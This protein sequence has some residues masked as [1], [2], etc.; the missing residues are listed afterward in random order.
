MSSSSAAALPTERLSWHFP[1]LLVRQRRQLFERAAYYGMF[2]A[3]TLYLTDRIGFDDVWTGYVGARSR[4]CCICCRRS[5]AFWPTASIG[6][7]AALM[8]AFAL[9]A[10]GYSLLGVAGLP[11]PHGCRRRDRHDDAGRVRPALRRA[12]SQAAGC[13]CPRLGHVRRLDHQAG[14][15]RH[16][17]PVLERSDAGPR[18]LH[19][20]RDG[21]H[22]LVHGQ[23]DRQHAARRLQDPQHRPAPHPRP[24]IHPASTPPR[25]R[26]W[27]SSSFASRIATSPSVRPARLCTRRRRA[28]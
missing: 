25:W 3:L 23:V 2:I 17:R 4:R 18:V 15:H 1:R 10:A 8:L 7:R 26:C 6:F 22:W 12:H 5:A 9:L 16:R 20:L 11:A 24:G 13:C 14:H 27:S 28:C 19:L 21:Q